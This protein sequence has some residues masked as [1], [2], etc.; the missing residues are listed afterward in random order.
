MQLLAHRGFWRA[1]AEQNSL[2]AL[3][4]AWRR[5]FGIETDLRD[6]AGRV[7]IAHDLARGIEPTL[8]ELVETLAALPG[9]AAPI[10]LNVKADGLAAACAALIGPVR[11]RVFF[12]DMSVPDMRAYLDLGLPVY[13]RHSDVEPT[14]AYYDRAAGVWLDQLHADWITADA[15]AAHLDR[16]KPVC[17]VSSELHRRDPRRLW[18]AL[19]PLRHAPGLSLCTDLFDQAAAELS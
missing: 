3:G 14:P 1:C 16:G 17:V 6:A 18:D 4:D 9:R 12:F 11:D 15:V 19:R 10:A 5:G 7:V 2:A 13:T 8:A